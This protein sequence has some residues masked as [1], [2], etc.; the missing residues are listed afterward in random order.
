[1]KKM[2]KHIIK[3]I[4]KSNDITQNYSSYSDYVRNAS[5][6]EKQIVIERA[7]K[8]ANDMQKELAA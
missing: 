2:I 4:S 6:K 5:D 8:S 1:M 3:R 7:V